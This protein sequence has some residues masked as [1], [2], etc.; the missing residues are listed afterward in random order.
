M[1][2]RAARADRV[3][4]ALAGGD[5]RLGGAQRAARAQRA[6]A[7]V[8]RE[9]GVAAR[10]R[11]AVGLAHGRQ[12]GELDGQV[13]VAHHAA[14]DGD[15]LGVLLAEE[16]DVGRDDVEELGHDRADAGE[17]AGPRSAPSSTSDSPSTRTDVA[18]P[19]G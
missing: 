18:N 5:R 11:E 12:D 17:V 7:L 16:R 6:R 3:G 19:G 13:E 9:A 4:V 14:Q 15:L 2:E 8:R 10:Q 1:A